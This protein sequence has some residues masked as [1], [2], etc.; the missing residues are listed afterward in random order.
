[1]KTRI[2]KRDWE[3]LSA[4]IDEQLTDRERSRLESRLQSDQNLQTAL[5]ELQHTRAILRS[6]PKLRAPRNYTLTRQ[7][8][9]E[10]RERPRVYPVL[11]FASALAT[12]LLVL[13]LVGDYFAP[14]AAIPAPVSESRAPSAAQPQAQQF[15]PSAPG[16]GGGAPEAAPSEEDQEQQKSIEV[17]PQGTPTPQPTRPPAMLAAPLAS[18]APAGESS[19]GATPQEIGPTP[20]P[21]TEQ[22]VPSTAVRGLGGAQLE[23]SATPQQEALPRGQVGRTLFFRVLEITLAAVAVIP[24]VAA[25]LIRRG[26]GG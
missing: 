26:P 4:Y 12:L 16:L 1:M 17:A 20:V 6:L 7:M 21:P 15:P 25:L 14:R 13:V 22:P 3:A 18:E 5:E 24:G 8:V 19:E 9:P 2:S 23:P 11:S 10:R